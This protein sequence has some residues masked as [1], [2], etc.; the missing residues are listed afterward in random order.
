MSEYERW[1]ALGER[2]A[3]KERK[4]PRSRPTYQ[5]TE[6]QRGYWDGYS[7]RSPE[8]ANRRQDLAWWAKREAA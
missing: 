2:Q 3:W 8:W 7:P 4:D 6:A 1:F 5:A